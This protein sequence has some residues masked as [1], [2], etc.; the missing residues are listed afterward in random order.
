MATTEKKPEVVQVTVGYLPATEPF[1]K[2]YGPEETL[3]TVRAEAMAYFEIADY[4]DRDQHTFHLHFS[5]QK[6]EDLGQRVGDLVGEH[7]KGL[8]LEIVEQVIAGAR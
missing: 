3:S 7:R 2:A 5:D 8:H 6:I 4:N 1:H